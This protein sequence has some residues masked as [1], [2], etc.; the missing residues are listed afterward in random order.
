MK[1]NVGVI[2]G[3]E[4]VEHEVSIISALQA[5]KAIDDSLYNVIPLYVSKKRQLY[6]SS[7]LMDIK[8]Y[9][10]LTN[11]MNKADEVYLINEGNKASLRP[12]S[13]KLFNKQYPIA[14][15]V[16]I[17]IMHGTNGEDG[18]IQGYLEMM[19]IPYAGCDV[20]AAGVGQDK[21]IM[22]YV[23]AGNGLPVCDWF[24]FY[25]H[26]Y[27][28]QQDKIK[29]QALALGYPLIIKPAC[30]GSSIGIQ[31]V[32]DPAELTSAINEASKYDRKLV[33]EKV[34][35][36]LMEINCSVLGDCYSCQASSL[37]QVLKNEDILSFSDKYIGK[38]KGSGSS[39]GMA[40]T[41]R[42]YPAMIDEVMTSQI[43]ELAIKTF[44]ALGA[45]GVCRIDFMV[46]RST[47]EIYVNEINTIP[48]SLAFY[49]WQ[50]CGV[51]FTE[52]MNKLIK[53][54]IDRQRRR[55]KMIFSYESNILAG[56][57]EG[58]K[59]KGRTK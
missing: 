53:Q 24:W 36:D 59:G 42:I 17:P 39:K 49:L 37:E 23:L 21:V 5:M 54:A 43:K 34:V 19:G 27:T 29:E 13:K 15:D 10:D 56:Y 4:S 2:F 50:D 6:Y 22:K 3:G 52:L 26:E 57:S 40:S 1:I 58:A 18:T 7:M 44:M 14:I 8:S 41:S 45:S 9:K 20:I 55:E 51:D 11:L 16:I 38:G 25:G 32:H 48:G 12:T 31:F 46:D 47:N 30:L 35:N 33:V 28:D